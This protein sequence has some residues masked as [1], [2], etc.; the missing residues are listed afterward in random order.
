M[1]LSYKRPNTTLLKEHSQTCGGTDSLTIYEAF[2]EWAT[3]YTPL[4]ISGTIQ[5]GSYGRRLRIHVLPSRLVY[6]SL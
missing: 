5:R 2:P 4:T 1:R 6:S 3:D